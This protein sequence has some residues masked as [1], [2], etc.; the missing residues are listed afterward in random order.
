MDRQRQRQT[1]TKRDE[2]DIF[3]LLQ[4][5]LQRAKEKAVEF[6]SLYQSLKERLQLKE[7]T[8]EQQEPIHS[9]VEVVKQQ[10]EEYKVGTLIKFLTEYE[11]IQHFADSIE[12]NYTCTMYMYV[13]TST[14][15]V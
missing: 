7:K 15:N 1:K 6:D 3:T 11:E 2:T 4:V 10:L 14:Y 12:I 8:L 13:Y 9:Q 5:L